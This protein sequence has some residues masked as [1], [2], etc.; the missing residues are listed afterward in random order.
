MEPGRGDSDIERL[1]KRQAVTPHRP[2]K[3]PRL[4]QADQR[5]SRAKAAS[6]LPQMAAQ[7]GDRKNSSSVHVT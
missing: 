6:H 4:F 7:L 1:R 5:E 2:A 3:W